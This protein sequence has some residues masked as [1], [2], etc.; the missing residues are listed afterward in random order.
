MAVYVILL[1]LSLVSAA[2]YWS[3]QFE[4]RKLQRQLDAAQ[5]MIDYVRRGVQLRI[6]QPLSVRESLRRYDEASR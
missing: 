5:P 3:V 6:W 2:G 4:R 1:V